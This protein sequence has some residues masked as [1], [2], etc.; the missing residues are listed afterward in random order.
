MWKKRYQKPGPHA[1]KSRELIAVCECDIRVFYNDRISLGTIKQLVMQLEKLCRKERVVFVSGTGKRKT[2]L[3]RYVE[4][5]RDYLQKIEDYV[6][7]L[8][9]CGDRNSYSKTDHD[10]TF[11]RMKEDAMLNGQLKPAYNV[12]HAVDG[13][14]TWVDA[15]PP[16]DTL[17]LCPMLAD[18]EKHLHFRYRD[19]V[20]DA[21][22]ESEE[23]YLFLESNGQASYI[24]PTNYEISKTRKYKT[25]IG[26]R[27]NMSYDKE[28]DSYTC[29]NGKKLNVCG[30]RRSRTKSGYV[31]VS[32]IYRCSECSG[33]PFKR[34][35]IRGN[36]CRTPWKNAPRFFMYQGTKEEKRAETSG[37]MSEYGT[38]LR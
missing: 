8:D 10:A 19:I 28:T 2:A 15:V 30:T 37:I 24:K 3:Q 4:Q 11:M 13:Y 12:Q 27:E 16:W 23:N 21:G 34:K 26:R 6:Y 36:N 14:I 32:T 7:K 1:G 29:R 33:C 5:A 25:D 22:Y 17:T 9:V 35:C 20:A 31:N 18:M 38:Q